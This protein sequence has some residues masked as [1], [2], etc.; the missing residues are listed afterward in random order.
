M[1]PGSLAR[2]GQ[3][4]PRYDL[5]D[6]GPPPKTE[7]A[8]RAGDR[9]AAAGDVVDVYPLTP[10]QQG[11]LFQWRLAPHTG[12]NIEQLVCVLPEEVSAQALRADWCRV[13]ERH[14]ALR[15]SFRWNSESDPRQEVH[16][17][18]IL[19]L[20]VHDLSP[21]SAAARDERLRSFLDEDRRLGFALDRLPLM[22]VS[23][24]RFGPADY[25]MVWSV[26]HI[27]LDARSF[28]GL[29]SQLFDP[30][31][32]V[33]GPPFADF[34]RAMTAR[35]LDDAERFWRA[36]LSGV[37]TP[38]LP[39]QL[40]RPAYAPGSRH[41]A[42]SEIEHVLGPHLEREITIDAAGCER[43]RQFAASSGVTPNTLVQAAWALALS[44]H[45]G[46]FD[47]VF[48]TVRACRTGHEHTQGM[49]INTVP[50]RVRIPRATALVDWL[51]ALR[52]QQI[53]IREHERTPLSKVREWSGLPAGAPLIQTL[54]FFDDRTIEG[55]MRA[56]GVWQTRGITLLE[57]T[58]FALSLSAYFERALLLKL[59][60]ATEM[61]ETSQIEELLGL[62]RL[63]LEVMPRDAAAEVCSLPT[64]TP[65]AR[66]RLRGW[67]RAPLG[68]AEDRAL[69]AL[70]E[71]Q[72]E[73]RPDEIALVAEEQSETTY[74]E[75]NERANRLAHLLISRGLRSEACVGIAMPPSAEMVTAALAVMKAGAAYVPLD[76][77]YPE[78]RLATMIEDARPML[79]LSTGDHAKDLPLGLAPLLRLEDLDQCL[80]GQ[81]RTNPMV[82][83]SPR[84]T[85]VVIFT[86]GSTGRP[87][88]VALTAGGIANH[89]AS[90]V[91][92]WEIGPGDRVLQL[93]TVNFD[94]SIEEMFV[95]LTS[96]ATLV[97]PGEATLAATS[98]LVRCLE[99]EKITILDATTPLWH[100]IVHYLAEHDARV[101]GSVRL[102]HVGGERATLATYNK[103][104]GVGGDRVRWIN[105]YGPTETT[106]ESTLYEVPAAE[107]GR[108]M[109]SDPPI[110]RPLANTFTYVLDEARRLVPPGVA[111]E[112]YIGGAG[113]ARGYLNQPELTEE[114]FLPDPFGCD[115]ATMYRTGD[116]VRYRADGELLY[117][118]R[119]DGQIKLRGHRIELGE[120]EA[121]LLA[122][123]RV[124]DAAVVV[125]KAPSGGEAL[126]AY[127]V[128]GAERSVPAPEELLGRLRERL[129]GFMVPALCMIVPAFPHTPSGKVDR[130]ALPAPAWSRVPTDR[131]PSPREGLLA[132][133]IEL[134]EELL[135]VSNLR[136]SDEWFALGGD[137][138][139]AMRLASKIE[140]RLG[141][142]VPVALL[143]THPTLGEYARALR[144]ELDSDELSHLLLIRDGARKKPCFL[145]HPVTGDALCYRALAN[146]LDYDQAI[147]GVQMRGLEGG[148]GARLSIEALAA[149]HVSE[150]Q[151][152]QRHGPYAIAGYSSGGLVAYA[153]ACQLASL[154]EEVE[155]LGLIDS[156]VPPRLAVPIDW[157]NPRHVARFGWNFLL[158]V[159]SLRYFTP[160]TALK[161]VMNKAETLVRGLRPRAVAPV[162]G[163]EQ[164]RADLQR[165]FVFDVGILSEQRIA[166]IQ[167][168]LRAVESYLPPAYSGPV[169]LFAS[170]RQPIFA[171]RGRTMGWEAVAAGP[172]VVKK[173][174]GNH[175]NMLDAAFVG[176]LAKLMSEAL[177]PPLRSLREGVAVRMA[178]SLYWLGSTGLPIG[179]LL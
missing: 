149:D 164:A 81:P 141:H 95:P 132:T 31:S 138:L 73:R 131:E 89:N 109:T 39:A 3:E 143:M 9:G 8:V 20:K 23:V 92:Q 111:G 38:A 139:L 99:R 48:G 156:D 171:P 101:P 93:S 4:A 88:G 84:S 34:V 42:S 97:I 74:R 102:C 44:A 76:P 94:A 22:R 136:P 121:H 53:A 90:I 118:D 61:F 24:F 140:S 49:L 163:L 119:V 83:V 169:T 157:K 153:M 56:R 135:G 52:A 18:G 47:V 66:E 167:E 161:I 159:W 106:I 41:P 142:T 33:D 113:V 124:R 158:A 65:E 175:A 86:S 128:L 105:A 7:R 125:R 129:P 35:E 30:A 154:G 72:A 98:R 28:P 96:G 75:L 177:H 67:G 168:H 46:S 80:L 54:L 178:G 146:T 50:F 162:D 133:V 19:D 63:L 151:S 137:S 77:S 14:P 148:A 59:E 10:L 152:V 122:D 117:L 40:A 144:E 87:K 15:T 62:V 110:G 134:W 79:I 165:L 27:I 21:L 116:R 91:R 12:V 29:L 68:L 82:E 5:A 85:A 179:G 114:R 70:I 16:R 150:I 147:Y 172:I 32:A 78:A 51:K 166:L 43:L 57:K 155:F 112:L 71:A 2:R 69:P 100:E 64:V 104:L 17:E 25:R 60:Y 108:E 103:W 115:A 26:H 173:V 127:V 126:I 130:N 174:K 36:Q 55:A 6:G 160:R 11:M 145:I 107:L 1:Y 13:I 170:E 45:T 176:E 37:E 58:P 120:V 123:V